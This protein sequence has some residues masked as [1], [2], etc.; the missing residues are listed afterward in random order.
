M[1]RTHV[2]I[3]S[4]SRTPI[5]GLSILMLV[6]GL[7]TATAAC[8]HPVATGH[9][10]ASRPHAGQAAAGLPHTPTGSHRQL[11][12][13]SASFVSASIGWLLAAPRCV[14][15]VRNPC[16]T[17][18]LR[19]TTDGGRTWMPAP[20]PPA[21]LYPGPFARRAAGVSHI[22]FASAREG[23]AFG[24]WLLQT[25]NAGATWHRGTVP[26]G[27]VQS[28][29]EGGGRLLAATG[30]CR[31]SEAWQCRFQV[32]TRLA[33]SGTWRPIPGARGLKV[34]SPSLV[35]AGRVGYVYATRPGL[36][37]PLLLTGPVNG[38]A[39]WRPARNPCRDA[40]SMAMAAA[41]GGWLFLGCGS[42]PGAGNQWKAAWI[43]SNGGRSWHAVA[44]P[45]IGGYLSAGSLT[46]GG[47]IFLSGGRMDVYISPNRG[48]SWF[49]SPSLNSA[50]GLANAGF[51]LSA[52]ATGNATGYAFQQ[53]V[54]SRQIWITRDAGRRWTSVTVR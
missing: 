27:P 16:T 39:D 5:P 6:A 41:P 42:E 40:W 34:S 45:P 37:K 49:T 12:V 35:V 19:K 7:A 13:I 47:T 24:P 1:A 48:R 25:R 31:Q 29:A 21:P 38:S 44:N 8:G 46:S 2:G 3:G 14:D 18:F 4:A 53:G 51:D 11:T 17:L 30:P 26:G 54:Y 36:A 22:L 20:A 43:S 52:Q 32:Y 15:Q 23:W 9:K 28:L 10:P 50:A 33:T